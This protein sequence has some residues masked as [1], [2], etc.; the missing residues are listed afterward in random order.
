MSEKLRRSGIDIIGDLPWGAHFCQFYRTKDDLTEVLIPYFKA[1]LESNELCL[2]ITAYPLRAEEAEEALR[3]AVP[4]FDVYLKNGQIE[5]IPYTYWYVKENIDSERALNGWIEKLSQAQEN[6]YEGV[7]FS[8]SF[9]WLK[10]ED[11]GNFVNY[12]RKANDV[13]SN[14]R[15]ISLCTY[16]LDAHDVTEALDIATNHQFSLVKKEGKW[17]QVDNSGRK[18]LNWHKRIEKT[19]PQN[20]QSIRLKPANMLS[21]DRETINLEFADII[22]RLYSLLWRISISLLTFP[23]V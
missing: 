22:S 15:I 12:E 8:W 7:R 1:G 5:I 14:Y 3:K 21:H 18:N 2:W 9:S 13:V 16:S 19:P 10:K 6:G 17:E 4:D 11:W 20:K 23:S